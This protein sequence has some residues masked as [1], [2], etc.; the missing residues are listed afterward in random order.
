[1]VSSHFS[2]AVVSLLL[3]IVVGSAC[4]WLFLENLKANRRVPLEAG[5]KSRR[6]RAVHLASVAS[7]LSLFAYAIFSPTA[8]FLVAGAAFSYAGLMV[9][10]QL[11]RVP[12][13]TRLF[14]APIMAIGS[15]FVGAV[16]HSWPEPSLSALT[17]ENWVVLALTAS[18][19]LLSSFVSMYS[20]P[21][22]YGERSL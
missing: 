14:L 10:L 2:N 19:V 20:V 12:W 11:A 15:V 8:L 22:G 13:R 4:V 6:Q 16:V 3:L 9:F 5:R 1:M 7:L 17:L 18:V 21:I